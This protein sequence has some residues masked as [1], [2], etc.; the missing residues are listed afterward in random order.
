MTQFPMQYQTQNTNLREL[1]SLSQTRN[2]S[3]CTLQD[4]WIPEKT[5]GLKPIFACFF[6]ISNCLAE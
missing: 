2:M 1:P 3:A 5:E 6:R 4:I